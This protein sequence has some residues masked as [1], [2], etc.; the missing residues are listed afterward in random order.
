[1]EYVVSEEVVNTEEV[2][3]MDETVV[4]NDVTE[5]ADTTD[6]GRRGRPRPNEVI[7]RDNMVFDAIVAAGVPLTRKQIAQLVDTKESHTYLSLLRLRQNG[8]LQ[9]TRTS[10][11]HFWSCI[12]DTSE[13]TTEADTSEVNTEVTS[14][15]VVT[16]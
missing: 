1:M 6:T 13:T 9:L 7:T 10:G 2:T 11:G 4:I 12:S 16:E 14:A 8:K 3:G 15:D 5:T